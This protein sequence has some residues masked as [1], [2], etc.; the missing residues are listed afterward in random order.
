MLA[1]SARIV[2]RASARRVGCFARASVDARWTL[3]RKELRLAFE[4]GMHAV[5]VA[6]RRVAI[7]DAS[8]VG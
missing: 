7:G 5:A 2:F 3:A 1:Q 4:S 6:L 8:A